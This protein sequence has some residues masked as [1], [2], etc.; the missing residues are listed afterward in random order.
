MEQ[1][2]QSQQQTKAE[3]AKRPKISNLNPYQEAFGRFDPNQHLPDPEKYEF[4]G[5]ANEITYDKKSN[6]ILI[7]GVTPTDGNTFTLQINGFMHYFYMEIPPDLELTPVDRVPKALHGAIFKVERV[8]RQNCY[9]V[10][11]PLKEYFK[12]YLHKPGSLKYIF[13]DWTKSGRF[14][15][16]SV[17][18]YEHSKVS[19]VI[20]FMVDFKLTGCGLFKLSPGCYSIADRRISSRQWD[21]MCSVS[22]IIAEDDGNNA[23][24]APMHCLY[25][26][27]EVLPRKDGGF[28]TPDECEIITISCVM[29]DWT[30][31][32]TLWKSIIHTGEIDGSHF[33]DTQCIEMES[34]TDLLLAFREVIVASDPD[35]LSGWN[36]EG[37]D[38]PFLYKRA[39]HIGATAF[40]QIG[41]LLGTAI[42]ARESS[43]NSAAHG[44]REYLQFDLLGRM[45]V[46]ALLVFKRN[47]KNLRSYTLNSV[48]QSVLKQT[49]EDV[50][51]SQI[52]RLYQGT[53]LERT[54]LASYCLKDSDLTCQL[55]EKKDFPQQYVQTARF[56][57]IPLPLLLTRGEQIKVAIKLMRYCRDKNLIIPFQETKDKWSPFEDT[58]TNLND[59]VEERM[60][61][62]I[63][64]FFNSTANGK[65]ISPAV[66]TT[67]GKQIKYAG[68]LVLKPKTG[69]HDDAP[70]YC[71]DFS[72]LYPS[73]MI[74]WNLCFS[75]LITQADLD[76]H[77]EWKENEHY[78]RFRSGHMF[79][80]PLVVKGV[81]PILAEQGLFF[82][83]E[84]K[85]LM[86]AAAKRGD[87]FEESVYNGQQ[88]AIKVFCNSM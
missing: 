24:L 49:K 18:F 47:V 56:I 46:D 13:K 78:R 12:C 8:K 10:D 29:R 43:F 81:L 88:N 45:S 76:R 85:K 72:S 11:Q 48:A 87:E 66:T 17:K 35:V 57:G 52:G 79:L 25:Y 55:L 51:H 65:I 5:Q 58:E 53:V 77:P 73:T 9:G 61:Q 19:P 22:D 2:Q 4:H 37:F 41:C 64:S 30:S 21:L 69:L 20:R 59:K 67:S 44:K 31:K 80:T 23:T 60:T 70:C 84:K 54:R 1:Q 62:R 27:I 39:K 3:A 63:T 16:G 68:A 83:G 82:R 86:A 26:D 6:C 28:P 33:P 32:K 7:Y 50:H 71:L 40:L 75:T 36:T 14:C 74:A 34:E 15:D 38:M 42:T